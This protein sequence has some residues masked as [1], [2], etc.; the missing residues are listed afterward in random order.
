MKQILL[1]SLL[2]LN[3]V[4]AAQT[5]SANK[6]DEKGKNDG[7]WTEYFKNG[8]KRYTGQ[9][10]HGVPTGEFKYFYE[11]TGKLKSQL[12][13]FGDGKMAAAYLYYPNGKVMA[14]GKYYDQKKDSV[15][16]Y[17]TVDNVLLSQEIYRR[18]VKFGIWKTFFS[19][20]KVS[21][22]E[23]WNNDVKEGSTAEF[24][25]DGKVM[26]E[27]VFVKG[28]PEG[29]FKTYYRNNITSSIGKYKAGVKDGEWLYRSEKGEQE[30]KEIYEGGQVVYTTQERV[31][32]WDSV[33][34]VVRS[35]ET[36]NL[37]FSTNYVHYYE[38]GKVQREGHFLKNAKHGEWKYYNKNGD[39]DSTISYVKGNRE[40]VLQTY[41]EGKL[42]TSTSFVHNKENGA[43]TEY[44][45][46]GT[47]KAE[48][49]FSKGKKQGTW[50]YYNQQGVVS[51]EEK[52]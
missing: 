42:A 24:Y 28:K 20:G 49:F 19:N 52:F 38:E 13:Y 23:T 3:F 8:K 9:F 35:R 46:D 36:Y 33:E 48:G 10:Q 47:K 7:A 17:Y 5:P 12:N 21:A 18:G 43:Y 4:L 1:F 45:G 26:K 2:L 22:L 25:D 15:W 39:L 50:K 34:T 6:P 16:N 32:Y 27:G 41:T 30:N 51:K 44:Y 31:S 37:D 29:L 11:E 40:G 14:S